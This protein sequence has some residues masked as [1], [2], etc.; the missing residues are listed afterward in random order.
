MKN[1]PNLTKNDNQQGETTSNRMHADNAREQTKKRGIS[2]S[3]G[4]AS[5][6]TSNKK[7]GGDQGNKR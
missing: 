5:Y 2:N 4:Q 7:A 3:G 6:E 1:Q